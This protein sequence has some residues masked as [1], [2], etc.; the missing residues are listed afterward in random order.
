[1]PVSVVIHECA[2][3]VVPL[4][5][6]LCPRGHA[7][8]YRHVDK[9]SVPQVLPQRTIAPVADEEVVIAVV[10][11]VADAASR[12]PTGTRD[13]RH[14][15]DIRKRAV[16]IILIQATDRRICSGPGAFE[17][18]PVYQKNIQPA[19]LIVVEEGG[20][21]SGCLDQVAITLLAAI[22][23]FRSQPRFSRHV[24][25]LHVRIQAL[26][27]L[28]QGKYRSGPTERVDKRTAACL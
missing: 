5:P 16:A 19:V 12:P 3:G 28:I 13:A 2:S 21:T 1:V 7:G 10:I 20:A 6:V 26:E 9:F 24:Y 8:L 4:T 17:L 11:E 27:K 14:R 25:K 23:G 22:S 18:R 15:C